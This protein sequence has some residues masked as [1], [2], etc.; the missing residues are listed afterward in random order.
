[1]NTVLS[2]IGL[3]LMALLL[4]YMSTIDYV[5]IDERQ[6]IEKWNRKR[7]LYYRIIATGMA[8]LGIF[9]IVNQKSL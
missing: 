6:S 9:V 4:F 2:G 1:M 3:I 8:G 7:Q 5:S